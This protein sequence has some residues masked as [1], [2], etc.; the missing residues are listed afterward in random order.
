MTDQDTNEPLVIASELRAAYEVADYEVAD[1]EV[2]GRGARVV[3]RIGARTPSIV[4]AAARP[5]R[6][7][8]VITAW[9]PFSAPLATDDNAVRQA[10]LVREVE[11]AARLWLP[12]LG[13]DPAGVWAPEPSLAVFDPVDDELDDWM[14]A[15]GQNAVVVAADTGT[16]ELRFH[17]H[18]RARLEVEGP[19]AERAAARVWARAFNVLEPDLLEGALH[20]DVVYTS[21][22]DGVSLE[23]RAAVREHLRR[24]LQTPRGAAAQ[25]AR[26]SAIAVD[27]TAGES[28]RPCAVTFEG[29]A[30]TPAAVVCFTLRHGS[31]A[32]VDVRSP[33]LPWPQRRDSRSSDS[34]V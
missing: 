9:N 24:A 29:A 20:D 10:R 16:C 2:E 18:E 19:V 27:T 33:E 31:I 12:A 23:G 6:R 14:L 34:A 15:F 11:R 5:W 32:R 8:A 22:Q 21:P 7:V 13:R 26:A 28:V 25:R 17:P 1:Y 4:L 3:L 30:T